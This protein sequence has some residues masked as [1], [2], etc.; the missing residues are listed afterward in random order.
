MATPTFAEA[1]TQLANYLHIPEEHNKFLR[2]NSDNFAGMEDTLVQSLKSDFA[3]EILGAVRALRSNHSNLLAQSGGGLGPLLRTVA[4]VIGS[5]RTDVDGIIDDLYDYMRDASTPQYVN[6][7]ELTYGGT[8]VDG[9]LG[10]ESLSET[11]FAT[12]ALWDVVG[13]FDDTGGNGAYTHSAGSGTLTQTSGN[14]AVAGVA[15]TWYAFTYTIT[16]PSGDAALTLTTAF[17]R[18]TQTLTV[19]AGTHTLHFLSNDSPGNFVISGT[20]TSGGVTID[21]VT[22]KAAGMTGNGEV[23][24]CT[25]DKDG[26]SIENVAAT[27]GGLT[28]ELEC[29]ADENSGTNPGEETFAIRYQSGAKDEIDFDAPSIEGSVTVLTPDGG[30][31]LQN[32]SFHDLDGT[33][34]APTTIPGWTWSGT[35]ASEL[36]LDSTNYY[37]TSPVEADNGTSYSLEIKANGTLSQTLDLSGISLSPDVPY[38]CL[39]A[40]NASVNS[41]DG[42]LT[43]HMGA[44]TASATTGSAPSG[45]NILAVPS[46]PGQNSWFKNFNEASM[47]IKIVL[48]SRTTGSI[49]VDHLIVAPFDNFAGNFFSIVQGRTNFQVDD[50]FTLTDTVSTE[51]IIQYWFYRL[52]GRY[53]PSVTGAAETISDP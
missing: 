21:D 48:A 33:V 5:N 27:S 11:N 25:T 28:W 32:P 31:G 18:E 43:L 37:A 30:I 46:T 38:L 53:L 15:N 50:K 49:L 42:T 24:R 4:K 20:S 35:V 10:S 22:L 9:T 29:I 34:A 1:M 26:F 45:W 39:L 47:D 6:S 19:T 41:G 40:Y 7:R 3:A 51:G 8:V 44:Q 16:S 17:A 2:T 13:D 23:Y 36:E 12:H 14:M 52:T